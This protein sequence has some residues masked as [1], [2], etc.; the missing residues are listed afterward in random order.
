MMFRLLLDEVQLPDQAGLLKKK[1][2]KNQL[3]ST[4]RIATLE[5]R[6]ARTQGR[7]FISLLTPLEA[8]A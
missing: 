6:A 4:S 3:G 5:I 2:K 7:G 8:L 1:Q